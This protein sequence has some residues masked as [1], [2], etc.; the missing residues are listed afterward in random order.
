MTITQRPVPRGAG[1][2]HE[3]G[4]PLLE[5]KVESMRLIVPK[6]VMRSAIAKKCRN[7]TCD[8]IEEIRHCP[9][10]CALRPFRPA[11][12]PGEWLAFANGF[13]AVDGRGDVADGG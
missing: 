10:A 11:Q 13:K 5:R 4:N 6:P 12:M 8:Q 7:C 2:T 1:H 3:V 9:V